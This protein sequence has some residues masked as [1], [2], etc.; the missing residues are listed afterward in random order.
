[1]K[2]RYR[3]VNA[4]YGEYVHSAGQCI[5]IET[6]LNEDIKT[7][8]SYIV[9]L[10][11]AVRDWDDDLFLNAIPAFRLETPNNAGE[12]YRNLR[13]MMYQLEAGV[14]IRSKPEIAK[15]QYARALRECDDV[16]KALAELP[17]TLPKNVDPPI[18]SLLHSVTFVIDY[19]ANVTPS[20]T[21]LQWKGPGQNPN[22]ASAAG[23]RTHG[24]VIAIGPPTGAPPVSEDASRLITLQA[25]RAINQQ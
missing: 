23:V 4:L 13:E 9:D 21:L 5:V 8:R 22:F 19:G 24:L 1:M 7:A 11:E 16:T 25:I 6:K 20:W 10:T 15:S 14:P 18:D 2:P 12:K 3:R 17:A